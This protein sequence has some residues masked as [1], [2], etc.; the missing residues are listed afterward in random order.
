MANQKHLSNLDRIIIENG[1]RDRLS[2]KY[3]ASKLNKDCTTISKEVLKNL[4]KRNSVSQGR[5]F[6]NCL[7]RY[8]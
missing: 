8:K 6:N 7:N 3:I 1:L 2:F 4:D 5:T